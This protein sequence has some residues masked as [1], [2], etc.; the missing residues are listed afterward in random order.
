MT[1]KETVTNYANTVAKLFTEKLAKRRAFWV[2][3]AIVFTG[4]FVKSIFQ[5]HILT[6]LFDGVVVVIS[7][8]VWMN[9]APKPDGTTHP[10]DHM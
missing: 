9:L 2:C 7:Y 3:M 6:A 8:V 1:T 4:M 10:W 5:A